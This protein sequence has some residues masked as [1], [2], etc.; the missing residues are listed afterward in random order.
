M[1][2]DPSE[3][4]LPDP[5]DPNAPDSKTVFRKELEGLVN[6]H[7]MENG[8]DTPD[9]ILAEYLADCLDAFDKAVTRREE[10]YGR[11]PQVMGGNGPDPGDG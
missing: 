4:D 8:S 7:S 9:F 10:W 3:I 6:C 1:T 2:T 11:A 5:P